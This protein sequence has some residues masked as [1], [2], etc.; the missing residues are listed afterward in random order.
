MPVRIVLIDWLLMME[1][2]VDSNQQQ[3]QRR[4]Q[5]LLQLSMNRNSL[6]N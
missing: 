5:R 4:R 3:Q 6:Q 2:K 1:V